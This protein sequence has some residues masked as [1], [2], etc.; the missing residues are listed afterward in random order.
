MPDIHLIIIIP[1]KSSSLAENLFNADLKLDNLKS[2]H[3]NFEKYNSEM[4]LPK[5]KLLIRISSPVLINKSGSGKLEV[6]RRL[7]N[8]IFT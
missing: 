8:V 5:K 2:G 3:S 7:E 6:D 4:N 1:F